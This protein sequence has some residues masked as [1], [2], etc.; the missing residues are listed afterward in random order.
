MIQYGEVGS[1]PVLFDM[2]NFFYCFER[3]Y[4]NEEA[5]YDE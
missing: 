4:P 2:S 3:S 5:K 1:E